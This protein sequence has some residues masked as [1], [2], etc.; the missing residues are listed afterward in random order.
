MINKEKIK[1]PEVPV[2]KFERVSVDADNTCWDICGPSLNYLNQTFGVE[3]SKDQI[4]EYWYFQ[5][6]LEELGISKEEIKQHI[7]EAYRRPDD[8]N[9]VYRDSKA[10][11]GMVEVLSDINQME[12]DLLVLT[13]RPPGLD[14]VLAQQFEAVGIEIG[15]DWV[16]GGNILIRDKEYWEKMSGA[17]F[18]WRA[19]RG[20][21]KYGKYR[22][23]PGIDCHFDDQGS[24]LD[25]QLAEGFQD[26]LMIVAWGFNQRL[27][28]MVP[29]D[30]RLSD[31][32]QFGQLVRVGARGELFNPTNV[33]Q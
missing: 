32:W 8:H 19:I 22:D 4:S 11:P 3:F 16:E 10:F 12:L 1:F 18:K 6:F 14:A 13:S 20:D 31:W 23:F 17:E 25:H 9:R 2:K 33:A 28:E 21:F 15:R 5:V 26:R 27:I 30:K 29:E 24:L 7:H